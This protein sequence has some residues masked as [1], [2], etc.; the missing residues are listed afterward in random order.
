M[1]FR[2]IR[3]RVAARFK[4]QKISAQHAGLE[5]QRQSYNQWTHRPSSST[6]MGL[7]TLFFVEA[8]APASF[9]R[10]VSAIQI[11]EKQRARLIW[12]TT[13][14]SEVESEKGDEIIIQKD[15]IESVHLRT[16]DRRRRCGVAW[17]K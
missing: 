8:T 1:G 11:G 3:P 7:Y 5:A 12:Q 2:N 14:L 16:K 15:V 4:K 17:S 6:T 9:G 13:A 10:R